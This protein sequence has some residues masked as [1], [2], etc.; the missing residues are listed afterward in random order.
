MTKRPSGFRYFLPNSPITNNEIIKSLLIKS[1]DESVINFLNHSELKKLRLYRGVMIILVCFKEKF[2]ITPLLLET[3]RLENCGDIFFEKISPQFER[4]PFFDFYYMVAKYLA[5]DYHPELWSSMI[6]ERFNTT[7]F[8]D[9]KEYTCSL[10]RGELNSYEH[11]GDMAKL[12]INILKDYD[13]R[14]TAKSNFRLGKDYSPST[15][16]RSLKNMYRA[17]KRIANNS[18]RNRNIF[19]TPPKG[20]TRKQKRK[21]RLKYRH[22]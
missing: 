22:F 1:H 5:G 15:K 13:T 12:Y 14:N 16:K 8:E 9:I 17:F 11:L 3:L 6:H 2:P 19:R 21:N 7:N 4:D 10:L 18:I 20:G